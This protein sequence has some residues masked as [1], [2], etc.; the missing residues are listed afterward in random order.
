MVNVVIV[1]TLG[2]SVNTMRLIYNLTA[3]IAI[4]VFIAAIINFLTW[5]FI[6]TASQL[7]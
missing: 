6:T 4:A 1:I 7:L 3:T 5:L 2:A